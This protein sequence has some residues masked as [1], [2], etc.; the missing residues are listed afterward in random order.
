MAYRSKDEDTKKEVKREKKCRI[1]IKDDTV[2]Y[3]DV[4][5]LTRFMNDRGK[6]LPRRVTGLCAKHQKLASQAIKTA[7]QMSLLANVDENIR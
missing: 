4:Q 5:S 6:I 7:R 1:C 2:D 3:K